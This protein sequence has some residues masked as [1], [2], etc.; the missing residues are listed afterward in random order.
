MAYRI[1]LISVKLMPHLDAL[2]TRQCNSLQIFAS[3]RQLHVVQQSEWQ[4]CLIQ[5]INKRAPGGGKA[6]RYKQ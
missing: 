2:R 5:E 3:K 1:R 6:V 4:R